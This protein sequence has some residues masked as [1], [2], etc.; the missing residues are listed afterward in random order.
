MKVHQKAQ[1]LVSMSGCVVRRVTHQTPAPIDY[2]GCLM[3]K[4]DKK[5][6]ELI[7]VV[8]LLRKQNLADDV[9]GCVVEHQLGAHGLTW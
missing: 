5:L 9:G 8:K 6:H 1:F 7:V 3:K 4:T 2:F